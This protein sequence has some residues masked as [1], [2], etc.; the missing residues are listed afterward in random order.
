MCNEDIDLLRA[1]GRE[2]VSGN[3]RDPRD[4][5]KHLADQVFKEPTAL[6]FR[7]SPKGRIEPDPEIEVPEVAHLAA[8]PFGSLDLEGSRSRPRN[9]LFAGVRQVH[10]SRR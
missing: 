5:L 2:D 3:H 7:S 9:S 8:N 6:L 4:G 10:E 1:P